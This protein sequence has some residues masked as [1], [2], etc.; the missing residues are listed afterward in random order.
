MV[1]I[2]IITFNKFPLYTKIIV[3]RLPLNMWYLMF[4][5]LSIVLVS[6]AELNV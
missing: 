4:Q 6:H 5:G 2:K 1:Y 3:S